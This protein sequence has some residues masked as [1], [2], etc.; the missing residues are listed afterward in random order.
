MFDGL[1]CC[2][3]DANN[4]GDYDDDWEFAPGVKVKGGLCKGMYKYKKIIHYVVFK[5]LRWGI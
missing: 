4:D 1:D 3:F 5:K 2:G